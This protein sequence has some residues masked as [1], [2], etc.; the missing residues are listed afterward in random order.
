VCEC[1]CVRAPARAY[2]TRMCVCARAYRR[3]HERVQMAPLKRTRT[4]SCANARVVG[5]IGSLQTLLSLLYY[6]IMAPVA[7][8]AAVAG[9]EGGEDIVVAQAVAVE[10]VGDAGVC[11]CVCVCMCVYVCACACPVCVRAY[12][13]HAVH[14]VHARRACLCAYRHMSHAHERAGAVPGLV[15]RADARR[16]FP[17]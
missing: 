11:V 15:R 8:V 3:M 12:A 10:D 1:V 6:T 7:T 14:A 13:V 17:G 9:D 5:Q 16:T 4:R 2:S